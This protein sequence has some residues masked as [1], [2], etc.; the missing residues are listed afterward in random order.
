MS[1]RDKVAVVGVGV[2]HLSAD[3]SSGLN[4]SDLGILAAKAALDDAGLDRSEL[5]GFAWSSG[6]NDPGAMAAQMGVPEVSFSATLT[7]GPG[8]G[9]GA[10]ALAASAVAGGFS[11]VC[12]SLVAVNQAQRTPGRTSSGTRVMTKAGPGA[13]G[14]PSGPDPDDAFSVPAGVITQA[15]R[16]AMVVNR[17]AHQYGVR[18]EHFGEVCITQRENAAARPD[19]T[20]R[21]PL[22][23]DEY[24]RAPFVVEPLSTYDCTLEIEGSYAVAVVTTGLDRARSLRQPPV[25]ISGAVVGGSPTEATTFQGDAD[26]FASAGHREVAAQLYEMA[27]VRPADVDV[28]LLYD[29]YSPMV[30]M[31][32]EDYG[33]CQVGEAGPLVEEGGIRY[34]GGRIPVNTHG[35]NLSDAYLRGVTHVVEAVEQIRGT[36]VR[37]VP[38][39]E[40]ALVTG[41]PALIP[42]SAA[43]LRRA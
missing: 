11:D 7:S 15:Q 35:G 40:V 21:K 19:S 16:F 32:L 18:R 41:S 34:D 24:L 5:R 22:S 30:L 37:Q 28:A 42:H 2:V 29:D 6:F 36:A 23:M 3:D 33:F 9:A 43:I 25:L 12:L 26:V 10:L 39:C 4:G 8:G 27:G 17:Y 20:G 38:D 1:L 13:Y 14:G 31:Q